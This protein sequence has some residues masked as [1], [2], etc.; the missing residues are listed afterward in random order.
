[1]EQL[2]ELRTAELVEVNERLKHLASYDSLTDLPNR[3]MFYEHLK[4]AAAH[5]RRT[6]QLVALLFL[7]LDGFKPVNDNYGHEVGDQLLQEVA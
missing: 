2:V 3:A 4:L 6:S 7:D 1:M 5:A